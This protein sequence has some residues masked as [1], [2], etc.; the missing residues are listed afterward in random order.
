MST[1]HHVQRFADGEV[2]FWI[3]QSSIHLKAASSHGDAAELTA[4]DAR[5][6]AAALIAAALQIDQ[7]CFRLI[8]HA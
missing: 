7:L 5:E 2:S 3:E 1:E 8:T 6:I 4:E